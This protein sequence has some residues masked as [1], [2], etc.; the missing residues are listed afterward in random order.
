MQMTVF[1]LMPSILLSGF[2]FP[3][4]GMP[5]AAQYIGELLPTT[6]FIR[7]TRGIMLREA[8]LGEIASDFYYLVGFTVVAMAVAAMRFT[9]SLD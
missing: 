1:I 7:L 6:H 8:P 4:D 9:K 3:F 2:M 5:V